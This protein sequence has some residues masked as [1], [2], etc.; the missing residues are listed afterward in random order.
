MRHPA[1]PSH[2]Q[3]GARDRLQAA[4]PGAGRCA[5]LFRPCSIPA[6]SPR[7]R[8]EIVESCRRRRVDAD[9]DGAIR[10]QEALAAAQT[11]S[12][13]RTV[14]AT[15]TRPRASAS[16]SPPSAR[17]TPPRDGGSRTRSPRSRRRWRRRERALEAALA[18]IPNLVHPETP[19]GGEADFRELRRV[20]APRRFAF[21]AARSRGARREARADRLRGGREGRRP[22]VLL[23]EERGGAARAGAPAPRA[24]RRDARRLHALRDAR[25]GAPERRRRPRL[26][27]ARRRDADLHD[28][29][30]RSRPDRDRRDHARRPARGRDPGGGGA[31]AA[32]RRR[33]ALLPHRGG[34]GRAREPRALPRAPVHEGGDVRDRAPG[35]LG[36]AARRDPRRRG[37]DLPGARDPLPRDRGRG[38]RSRRARLPQ[39]RPRGLAAGTRRRAATGAR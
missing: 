39:V 19:D 6:A 27:P 24:R 11:G 4:W 8:D 2:P 29:G 23:P 7:R 25:P 3:S 16:S 5:S 36:G 38:G 10:A 32:T 17:R 1:S 35:G 26:Q 12:A 31:P 28:R 21:T 20:G 14:C 13:R 34:R 15:S 18:S 9:V 30:H 33:V 37:G 22:E